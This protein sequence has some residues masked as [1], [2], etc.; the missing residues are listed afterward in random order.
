GSGTNMAQP[1]APWL[2]GVA[3]GS[4]P[5]IATLSDGSWVTAWAGGDG[6]LWIGTG[7]G[8]NM[9]RPAEPW[10]LDVFPGTSPSITALSTGG[11]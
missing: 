11:W 1:A 8:T 5:S 4:K 7:I 3:Q 9:A 2:L 6:K 10:L